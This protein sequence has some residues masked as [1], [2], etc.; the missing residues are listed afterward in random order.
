MTGHPSLVV[1]Q[2]LHLRDAAFGGVCVARLEGIAHCR[3]VKIGLFFFQA[4]DGIR[5]DLVTE[6]QTC[7]LPIWLFL[8][9]IGDDDAANFLLTFLDPLNNDA[10]VQRSDVHAYAPGLRKGQPKEALALGKGDCQLY[11]SRWQSQRASANPVQW[12]LARAGRRA[13]SR[14]S[15][16]SLD[17][18]FAHLPR[19]R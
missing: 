18:V 2:S 5:D 7:A 10:V 11:W 14:L 12:P 19:E 16:P 13:P 4:E 3:L 6:V 17:F 8:R 9:G 15:R 1:A